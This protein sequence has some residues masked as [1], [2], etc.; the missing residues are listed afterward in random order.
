MVMLLFVV[1]LYV[2]NNCNFIVTKFSFDQIRYTYFLNEPV[3]EELKIK[4]IIFIQ[5][6]ED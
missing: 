1:C 2:Y 5:V 4:G 6:E 3:L